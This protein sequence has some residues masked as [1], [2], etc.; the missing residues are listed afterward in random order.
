MTRRG[1]L[2][3][4]TMSVIWGVPYL[5]IKV[6]VH[7]LDPVVVAAGRTT[8][9]AL[10]LLPIAVARRS[11]APVFRRWKWLLAYTIAE[12]SGP[13]VLLGHAET[14]LSSS[15]TG[16]LVAM[17]PLVAAVIL[18]VTGHDRLDRRRILGLAVGFAG[19][20]ILVG[21]DI[22]G[23]L[24]SVGAVLLVSVGY[25]LGPILINRKLADL[26]PIGVVTAS[27]AVA[28]VLYWPFVPFLW[29]THTVH[30]NALL[31][32]LGLAVICTAIAFL[33]FFALIAEVGPARSTVITYINPAV[34]LLLGVLVLGEKFTVGMA[35]GFPL[36]I[37]GSVLA[38]AKARVKAP[39]AEP[40]AA[41]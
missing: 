37:L 35:I 23:D 7:D 3:F 32:V 19:V 21:L 5:M 30:V 27:L 24:L 8:L 39:L 28:A 41:G 4:L 14:Q 31:S 18:W 11:L 38:T 10:L 6:A 16:L 17:V 34:A 33:L 40:V 26:P 15:T 22:R 29:P 20:A 25:A 12:I 36:V 2:L 1:W 13:W 9:G